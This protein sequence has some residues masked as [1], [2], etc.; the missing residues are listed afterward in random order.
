MGKFEYGDRMMLLFA[1]TLCKIKNKKK[2]SLQRD[3]KRDL[4]LLA[5]FHLDDDAFLGV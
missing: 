1:F 4:F 2:L 3:S 5:F